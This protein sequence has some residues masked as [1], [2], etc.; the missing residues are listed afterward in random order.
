MDKDD[1]FRVVIP[2]ENTNLHHWYHEAI[3]IIAL[4]PSEFKLSVGSL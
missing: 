1:G 2:I 4:S 3:F